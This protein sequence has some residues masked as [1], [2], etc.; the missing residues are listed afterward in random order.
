MRWST[1]TSAR[2]NTDHVALVDDGVLHGLASPVHLIDLLGDDGTQLSEAAQRARSDPWEIVA[3]EDATLRAPV[4]V[5]PSIRDFMAF[6]EHVVTSTEA[7]G[8]S[9]DPVWYAMPLFYFS[10]P[11]AVPGA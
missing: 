9:V 6:E 3:V 4:P 1:Y 11:A 10:N 5:P 2:D 8:H 7:L